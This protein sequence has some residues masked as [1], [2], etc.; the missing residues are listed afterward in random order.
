MTVDVDIFGPCKL[1]RPRAVFFHAI[2]GTFHTILL[3]VTL[4]YT[5]PVSGALNSNV[6][7]PL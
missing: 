2:G 4:E 5:E 3:Y 7:E 6:N 1:H